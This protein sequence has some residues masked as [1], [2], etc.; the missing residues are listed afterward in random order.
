MAV[1]VAAKL[2]TVGFAIAQNDWAAVPVGAAGLP[3][4]AVTSNL[5]IPSQPE[6][7]CEA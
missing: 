3:T 6:T 2:A 7:V 1:P 5:K 4:V